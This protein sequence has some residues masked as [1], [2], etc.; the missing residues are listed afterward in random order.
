MASGIMTLSQM[1]EL[2]EPIML[3]NFD[4]L[5]DL[6][7]KELDFAFEKREGMKRSSHQE[8]VIYGMSQASFIGDGEPVPF[9]QG[10]M[11]YMITY[12]YRN[13]GMGFSIT[14]NAL[15]DGE[16]FNIAETF[17]S[18]LR[19]SMEET[20]EWWKAN[21]FN[22]GFNP[23]Y[24]QTGGTGQPLFSTSQPLAT[25]GVYSNMA[26]TPSQLS[27]TSLEQALIQIRNT[28]DARGKKIRVTPDA[29]IIPVALQFQAKVILQ[30]ILDPSATP[31]GG[32]GSNAINPINDL[33]DLT[34]KNLDL[35]IVSRFTSNTAWFIKNDLNSSKGN[36]GLAEFVRREPT[37]SSKEDFLT[38][39][40]NFKFTRR[41]AIGWKDPRAVYGNAG[42]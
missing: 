20:D 4:G 7:K 40:V 18:H 15:E 41:K 34:N 30:S 39:C 32:F 12:P 29:L 14:E 2:V 6:R 10:G 24:S 13:I 31:N 36:F 26:S 42:A 8:S 35:H 11:Q 27:V 23:Q 19:Q 9:D 38:G 17:S 22:Q 37:F 16:H 21:L 25:S 1:R 3:E 33:K 5:Y 28:V